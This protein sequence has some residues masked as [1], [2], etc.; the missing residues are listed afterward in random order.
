M[1]SESL[2]PEPPSKWLDTL[3]WFG[4]GWVFSAC[5]I[6]T[7]ELI[8]TTRAASLYGWAFLWCVPLITFCKGISTMSVTRYGALTGRTFIEG[9]WEIKWL[10]WIIPYCTLSSF[11]YLIGIGAHVGI[12]AGTLA[13]LVPGALAPDAWIVLVVIMVSLIG[14]MG[15][16]NI[17]E[18]M[19]ISFVLMMSFGIIAVSILIFPPLNEILG[20]LIPQMPPNAIDDVAFTTWIGLWGWLGAGWGPTL[21]YAWWAK[22]KGAGMYQVSSNNISLEQLRPT[23]KKRLK[24][25]LRLVYL[26]LLVSYSLTFILSMCLYVS[27][28]MVLF[29]RGLHPAGIS[30]IET[31]SIMFTETFGLWAR[32]LFLLGGFALLFSSV[33]GVVDGL[34]RANTEFV[35][36]VSAPIYNKI[37]HKTLLRIFV[38]ASIAVPMIFVFAVQ[39]PIWLLQFSSFMFAPAMGIIFLTSTYL[40]L[41]LPKEFRPHPLVTGVTVMTALFLVAISLLQFTI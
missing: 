40:S 29:P 1:P 26:D 23:D 33:L 34:S 21:G 12:T 28:A 7:G 14:L 24:G 6:G 35:K 39:R 19:M 20:G 15:Y 10:R 9:I 31:L 25:W 27:G 41:R 2:I 22:E 37:G 32:Y 4:P 18:K 5:M 3:G 17:L 30:L 38:L 13:L 8:L 11:L 16:Y 36:I